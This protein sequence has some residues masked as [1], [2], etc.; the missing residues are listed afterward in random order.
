MD[1]SGHNRGSAVLL[2]TVTLASNIARLCVL[3][4]AYNADIRVA[5]DTVAP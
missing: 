1:R 3:R 4:Q 2:S 5:I